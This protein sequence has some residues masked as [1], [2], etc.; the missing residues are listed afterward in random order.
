M[1]SARMSLGSIFGAVSQTA[2]TIT[3]T[4]ETVNHAVGMANE[5]ISNMAIQQKVRSKLDNAAFEATV[6]IEKSKE[7]AEVTLDGAKFRAQS[8]AHAQAYDQAFAQYVAVLNK[9]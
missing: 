8:E 1:A 2:G 5:A 3:S 6:L 9:K 7:L 4:L